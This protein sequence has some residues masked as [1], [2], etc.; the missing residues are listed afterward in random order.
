VEKECKTHIC[1][2]CGKTAYYRKLLNSDEYKI[3]IRP[4]IIEDDET[5]SAYSFPL[6]KENYEKY[7]KMLNR[8][9]KK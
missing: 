1:P 5:N 2:H 7:I 3:W 4:K 6:V 8:L 9:N